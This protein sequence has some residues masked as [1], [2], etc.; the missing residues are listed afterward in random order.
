MTESNVYEIIKIYLNKAIEQ[1]MNSPEKIQHVTIL[2]EYLLLAHVKSL[3]W[4]PPFE[5][6]RHIILKKTIEFKNTQYLQANAKRYYHCIAALDEMQSFLQ[7][8]PPF[9]RSERLKHKFIATM[10]ETIQDGCICTDCIMKIAQL[11]TAL[12]EAK[13][14]V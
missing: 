11:K 7:H 13:N 12:Y 9:R 6:L 2:Y 3:L 4:T 8:L 14:K 5:K 10:N 1:P